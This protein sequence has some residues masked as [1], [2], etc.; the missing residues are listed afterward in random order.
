MMML[1]CR[2]SRAIWTCARVCERWGSGG[3]GAGQEGVETLRGGEDAE[4]GEA[5]SDEGE[6]G[7]NGAPVEEGGNGY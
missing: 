3:A 2:S 4:C 6:G 5:G 1:G 7:F